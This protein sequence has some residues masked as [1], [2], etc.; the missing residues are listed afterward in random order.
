MK[1][2]KYVSGN[3]TKNIILQKQEHTFKEQHNV[4]AL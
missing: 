3:I 2:G 4:M 1:C